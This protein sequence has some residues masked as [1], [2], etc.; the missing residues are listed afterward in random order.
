MNIVSPSSF[1][2]ERKSNHLAHMDQDLD[3]LTVLVNV[4]VDDDGCI[5]V[6]DRD[7][8]KVNTRWKFYHRYRGWQEREKS[9]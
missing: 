4:A 8:S 1:Q 5:L 2:E 6:R 9:N 7:N 3:S